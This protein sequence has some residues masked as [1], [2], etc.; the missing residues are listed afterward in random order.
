MS[1][2]KICEKE[3]N[4]YK[5]K[6]TLSDIEPPRRVGVDLRYKTNLEVCPGCGFVSVLGADLD[7]L[8]MLGNGYPEVS[9]DDLERI[10]VHSILE[11]MEPPYTHSREVKIWITKD[12]FRKVQLDD[13]S[14][15]I[16]FDHANYYRLVH[17]LL[18]SREER[19][20]IT[21]RC[22]CPV[23]EFIEISKERIIASFKDGRRR[24]SLLS[25]LGAKRIPVA[26]VDTLLEDAVREGF[27][28]YSEK[29]E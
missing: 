18:L 8:K 13:L 25:H 29:G 9:K 23:I 1:Y 10:D 2:C 16:T 17:Y 27:V 14:N 21:G 11:E 3:V 20:V 26:V 7:F 22:K 4:K 19:E 28:F 12:C 24:F 5:V 15:G 6:A